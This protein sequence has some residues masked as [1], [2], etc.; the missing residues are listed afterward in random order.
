MSCTGSLKA[1][2]HTARRSLQMS[3]FTLEYISALESRS[4]KDGSIGSQTGR[5][6]PTPNQEEVGTVSVVIWCLFCLAKG[7]KE[8][9]SD[10]Q[11]YDPKEGVG[12]REDRS[13]L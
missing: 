3:K 5:L 6:P 10:C 12:D 8:A 9:S 11:S 1:F 2:Q 4:A 13:Q 7:S